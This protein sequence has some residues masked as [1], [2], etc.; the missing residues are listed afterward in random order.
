MCFLKVRA[1]RCLRHKIHTYTHAHR[2][3]DSANA[4]RFSFPLPWKFINCTYS[5]PRP[6][7]KQIVQFYFSL[8]I[9]DT[10]HLQS[11]KLFNTAKNALDFISRRSVK[12]IALGRKADHISWAYLPLQTAHSL[13]CPGVHAGLCR[14]PCAV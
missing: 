8:P 11:P 2:G 1:S 7:E 10:V 4:Q 14:P 13:D 5:L 3:P 6:L 9:A 12:Q